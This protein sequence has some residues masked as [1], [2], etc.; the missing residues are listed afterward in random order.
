ME[1]AT[2]FLAFVINNWETILGAAVATVAAGA[3]IA[4]V[5]PSPKDDKA[6]AAVLKF[7]NLVPVKRDGE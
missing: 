3:A 7:L 5:T 1:N 6:F 4:K 2:G